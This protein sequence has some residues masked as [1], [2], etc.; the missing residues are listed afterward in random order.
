MDLAS[1]FGWRQPVNISL[2]QKG[3]MTVAQVTTY[4]GMWADSQRTDNVVSP[5]MFTSSQ[6]RPFRYK[7]CC[8]PISIPS[9]VLLFLWRLAAVMLLSIDTTLTVVGLVLSCVPL[10]GIAVRAMS[11]GR[12]PRPRSDSN[13]MY[14]C[15]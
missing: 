15:P 11:K 3:D 14:M 13:G 8:S 12:R 7:R 1:I 9:L 6:L 10:V 5:G 4:P 2:W